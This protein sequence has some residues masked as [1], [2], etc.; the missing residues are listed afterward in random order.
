ME[1]DDFL[2]PKKVRCVNNENRRDLTKGKLYDV[3]GATY[4]RLKIRDDNGGIS[5]HD[6]D[7]F[8]LVIESAE[9]PLQD[10]KLTPEF[11][12][13]EPKFKV[14]DK[15]YI[16][17]IK[18]LCTIRNDGKVITS[19]G[20]Y[21]CN[22]SDSHDLCFVLATQENCEMLCKLYPHIEFEQPPKPLSGDELVRAML[23]KG[24]KNVLCLWG[25]GDKIIV[26]RL[27]YK[28]SLMSTNC[29]IVGGLTPIDWYTGEPLTESVLDETATATNAPVA[30]EESD[31]QADSDHYG[32]A[33]NQGGE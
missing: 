29:N 20:Q 11:E 25:N 26:D 9:N 12:A 23:T 30:T 8:E 13:V 28:G 14:G 33:D 22:L 7:F 15:V 10:M 5:W 4:G 2:K 27:D 6:M 21:Y 3:A 18:N 16:P 32:Y 1:L 31:Q 17:N 24:I 19:N